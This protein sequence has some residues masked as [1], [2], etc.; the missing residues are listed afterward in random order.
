[1]FSVWCLES[2]VWSLM[3]GVQ[4]LGFRRCTVVEEGGVRREMIKWWCLEVDVED[5]EFRA[6]ALYRRR[7]RA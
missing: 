6:Q 3:F 7:G 1:M 5:F 2:V 4:G